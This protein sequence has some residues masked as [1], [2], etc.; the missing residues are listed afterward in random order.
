MSDPGDGYGQ[1]GPSAD[2]HNANLGEERRDKW[3]YAFS[4]DVM[5]PFATHAQKHKH[6]IGEGNIDESVHTFSA[7]DT[8]VLP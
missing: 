8:H 2:N 5:P 6:D 3:V 4:K 7:E 1:D